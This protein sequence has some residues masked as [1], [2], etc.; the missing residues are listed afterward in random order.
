MKPQATTMHEYLNALPADRREAI[1]AV[2]YLVNRADSSGGM[3]ASA[4]TTARHTARSGTKYSAE[5]RR[6]SVLSWV[7]YDWPC[8]PTSDRR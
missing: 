6:S 4:L 8:G 5:R 2:R 3:D 1:S 7:R